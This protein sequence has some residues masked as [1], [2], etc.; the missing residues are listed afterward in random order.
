MNDSIDTLNL[1]R[2]DLVKILTTYNDN[3]NMLLKAICSKETNPV[4]SNQP[5]TNTPNK[6]VKQMSLPSHTSMMSE[7]INKVNEK[8]NAKVKFQSVLQM[9]NKF[10]LE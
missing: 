5:V 6:L 2:D 1:S 4:V 9:I 8:N 10:N 7:L 3:I